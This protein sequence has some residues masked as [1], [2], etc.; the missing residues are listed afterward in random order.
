MRELSEK[1][2]LA[3]VFGATGNM[4]FALGNVL[5][6]LKK[7]NPELKADILVFEQRIT[8]KDKNL[9]NTILTCK[10]IEYKFPHQGSLTDETLKKFS[11]LTFSRFECFDLLSEYKKVLW[12]DVDILI[13]RDISGIF[14]QQSKGISLS[15]GDVNSTDFNIEMEGLNTGDIKYNA[16][17]MFLQDNLPAFEELKTWCYEKT[18]EL[19][20]Y[21]KSADQGIINLMIKEKKLTVYLLDIEYNFNPIFNQNGDA[22]EGIILH[23]FCPEKFW[24]YWNNKEWNE[25]NKKWISIGGT[26]YKGKEIGRFYI[27][28]KEVPNPLKKT[29]GF[30]KYLIEKFVS[31]II[32]I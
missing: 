14:E 5:I 22:R 31:N 1:K 27:N 11:E 4:A 32:R 12:L 26:P 2:E 6:G 17:V 15:I 13:K 30:V 24:N 28:L 8:E 23:T 20:P 21:L 29:G 25:N 3:I 7:H 9:L 10:F 16:G 19:A 18:L